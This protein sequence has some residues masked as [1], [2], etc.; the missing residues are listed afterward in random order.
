MK[1]PE[2]GDIIE[3]VD[4][5]LPNYGKQYTLMFKPYPDCRLWS[6]GK[7]KNVDA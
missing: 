6:Y 1:D 2:K 3:I 5:K 7:K 4:E